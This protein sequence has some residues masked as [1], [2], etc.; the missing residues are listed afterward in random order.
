MFVP[1][2]ISL[3]QSLTMFDPNLISL[4]QSLTVLVPNLI[5]LVQNLTVL[6]PNLI[7]LVQSLTMFVP[8]QYQEEFM[9]YPEIINKLVCLEGIIIELIG[10]WIWV[11][12]NTYEHREVIKQTGFMFAPSKCMWYHR[13]PDYKSTNREPKTIEYIRFKY[14]SEVVDAKH[15]NFSLTS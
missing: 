1:N 6:V 12:G 15:G 5:S 4:V 10:N 3:V 2:L 11:S 9:K 8:N 14:G 7:S 13:P